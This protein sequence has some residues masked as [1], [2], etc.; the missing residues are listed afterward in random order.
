MGSCVCTLNLSYTALVAPMVLAAMSSITMGLAC[1]C[2]GTVGR[3]PCCAC[4]RLSLGFERPAAADMQ[5]RSCSACFTSNA[6]P[7]IHMTWCKF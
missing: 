3:A 4:C 1:S 2:T 7:C 6:V 5:V